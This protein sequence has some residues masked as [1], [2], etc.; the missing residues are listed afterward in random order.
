MTSWG[1][2]PGEGTLRRPADG[3]ATQVFREMGSDPNFRNPGRV[4]A[5]AAA[6]DE[7]DDEEQDDGAEQRDQE[8]PDAEVVLVDGAGAEER[9]QE[10]AAQ[11]GAD[12]AHDD[13]EEDPHL[14]VALHDHARDPAEEAPDD[15]PKN[16]GHG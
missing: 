8:R 1:A 9:R 4:R 15:Q 11:E 7:V 16:E 2:R 12:D 3:R 5:A 13:V 14:V 10:Q 6:E